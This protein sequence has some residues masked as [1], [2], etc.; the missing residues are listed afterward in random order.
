M[1]L[2]ATDKELEGTPLFRSLARRFYALA[3]ELEKEAA[4]MWHAYGINTDPEAA[5]LFEGQAIQ[6]EESVKRIRALLP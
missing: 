4:D 5:A 6:L 3:N 2:E 1:M